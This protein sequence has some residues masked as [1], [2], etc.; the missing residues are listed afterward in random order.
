MRP[1]AVPLILAF[2]GS[3]FTGSALSEETPSVYGRGDDIQV[4]G[5]T[6][7]RTVEQVARETAAGEQADNAAELSRKAAAVSA[8]VRAW[9]GLTDQ[10]GW[11]RYR[12]NAFDRGDSRLVVFK[13]EPC[14]ASLLSKGASDDAPTGSF[15]R[16]PEGTL[17]IGWTDPQK[18]EVFL[19]GNAAIP[20]DVTT[21]VDAVCTR[22]EALRSL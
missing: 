10:T 1:P 20:S 6:N 16:T 4:E 18:G 15:T 22:F 8:A 5:I 2:V 13:D 17:S 7:F 14:S 3:A 9:D 12:G 11:T 19:A 21:T